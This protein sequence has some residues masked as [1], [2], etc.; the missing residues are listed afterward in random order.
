[1]AFYAYL[2]RKD[3]FGFSLAFSIPFY[4]YK[5]KSWMN[6]LDELGLDPFAKRKL[7]MYVGGEGFEKRFVKGAIKMKDYLYSKGYN[8]NNFEFY[9]NPEL[10]HHEEAW[11]EYSKPALRFWLKDLN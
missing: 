7:A 9:H 10:P 1:M 8:E 2:Y 6:I 11:A 5:E 4:F 3:I